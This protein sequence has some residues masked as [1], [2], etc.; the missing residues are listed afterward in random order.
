MDGVII[1]VVD[2]WFKAYKEILIRMKIQEKDIYNMDETG[3]SI[4]TME[5]T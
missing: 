1:L 3:F 2:A 4:R 5:L